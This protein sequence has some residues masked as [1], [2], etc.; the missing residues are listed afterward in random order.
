MDNTKLHHGDYV[1]GLTE[2]QYRDILQI[3]Y[4]ACD[5][6]GILYIEE[7]IRECVESG[8]LVSDTSEGGVVT[9][10]CDS[11]LITRLTFTEFRDRAINTFKK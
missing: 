5:L 9:L 8:V 2:E 6:H 1:E 4:E 7:D 3:E 11:P 10:L